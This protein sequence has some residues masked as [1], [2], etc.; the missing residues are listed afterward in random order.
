MLSEKQINL[1]ES[2]GLTRISTDGGACIYYTYYFRPV[3][4]IY[5]KLTV[6]DYNG[7]KVT[8]KD[9]LFYTLQVKTLGDDE[10]DSKPFHGFNGAYID[11]G[12]Y[13]STT[14]NTIKEKYGL[15]E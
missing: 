4:G 2:Q 1:I 11:K 5:L 15:S 10:I 7:K 14:F 8:F 6:E 3:N 9:K 12:L 13:L